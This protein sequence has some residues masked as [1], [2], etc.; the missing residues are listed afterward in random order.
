MREKPLLIRMKARL[1]M[2]DRHRRKRPAM[3]ISIWMSL[4]KNKRPGVFVSVRSNLKHSP[5][6]SLCL[7]S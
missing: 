3:N 6:G 4:R 1:R 5:H 7:E 2:L